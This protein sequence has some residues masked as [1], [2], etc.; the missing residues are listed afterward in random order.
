MK[1]NRGKEGG[2]KGLSCVG[3]GDKI[4]REVARPPKQPSKE[5]RQELEPFPCWG[6]LYP[7]VLEV[8]GKEGTMPL[9]HEERQV[10][11]AFAWL[12]GTGRRA[13]SWEMAR[14]WNSTSSEAFYM[15]S[16]TYQVG[17]RTANTE[18]HTGFKVTTFHY[19]SGDMEWMWMMTK[20]TAVEWMDVDPLWM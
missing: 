16:N 6:L 4:H 11:M 15:S 9:A 2:H 3:S 18:V 20:I 1:E 5:G 7:A 13:T 19:T 12:S 10:F 17:R 14:W 8:V